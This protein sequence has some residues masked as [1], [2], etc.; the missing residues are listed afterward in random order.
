MIFEESYT[1][2]SL[3]CDASDKL[4]L[5]GVA[6]LFQ[7]VAEHHTSLTHIGFEDLMKEKKAWV[8][9][10]MYYRITRLPAVG[11]T[12]TLKTWSRGTNGL[13]AFRDY[14]MVDACGN[15]IIS[16]T[17]DWVLIDFEKRHACRLYDIMEHYEHHDICATERNH[18]DKLK[19]PEVNP[20]NL[21]SA[22]DVRE[23]MIDHTQHVN[24]AEYLRL[25]DDSI[26]KADE[27]LET[28]E[29]VFSN[30][31]HR[32]EQMQIFRIQ[33]D[34]F[35]FFQISNPREVAVKAKATFK[36]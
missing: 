13:F 7:E 23:S 33:T 25:I 17:S 15:A 4:S 16:A 10:R 26:N 14:L 28:L 21:I 18:F 20:N 35:S 19:L 3:M 6:R 9:S 27:H 22:I 8:L 32:H 24:N 34:E 29:I 12:V 31:T 2:L 1:I 5:W 11:E 30:E 36:N